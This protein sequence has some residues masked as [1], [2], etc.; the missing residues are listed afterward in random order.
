MEQ[1]KNMVD[2]KELSEH[3][4]NIG[5]YIV[6]GNIVTSVGCNFIQFGIQF[7]KM[8]SLDFQPG[9]YGVDL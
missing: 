5:P 4:D 7:G 9:W 3:Y 6:D 1:M 2:I 8:L